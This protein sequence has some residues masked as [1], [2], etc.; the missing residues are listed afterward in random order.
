[1]YFNKFK[2]RL[3]KITELLERNK[4]SNMRKINKLLLEMIV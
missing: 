4:E 3:N 1:M 2:Y